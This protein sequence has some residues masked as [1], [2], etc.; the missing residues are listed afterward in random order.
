V[1]ARALV[2]SRGKGSATEV[3]HQL[4]ITFLF[5]K[6]KIADHFLKTYHWVKKAKITLW[7]GVFLFAIF[8]DHKLCV[9][10]C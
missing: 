5:L 10:V 6:K 1:C 4:L 2:Y 3:V 9:F 7:E 8:S